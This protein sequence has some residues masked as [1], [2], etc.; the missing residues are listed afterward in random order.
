MSQNQ[1]KQGGSDRMSQQQYSIPVSDIIQTDKALREVDRESA[2]YKEMV[3]SI[4]QVGITNPISVRKM[5][6]G[7]YE[8]IDGRHR[9]NGAADAGLTEI[10]CLVFEDLSEK[11]QLDMQI[12]S[13]T[14]KQ[15]TK[16]AQ[17]ANQL[18]RLMA[19]DQMLTAG[20]IAKRIGRSIQWVTNTLRLNRLLDEAQKLVDAGDICLSNAY[21]LAQLPQDEQI[22]WI[23]RAVTSS[24]EIF[25]PECVARIK[26]L[27]DAARKGKTTGPPVFEPTARLRKAAVLKSELETGEQATQSLNPETFTEAIKWALQLDDVTVDADRAS[28]EEREAAR[29]EEKKNRAT[30]RAKAKEEKAKVAVENAEAN[31]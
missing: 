23:E 8:L 11:D 4:V 26:E 24:S 13:N 16:P 1:I 7:T 17:Y 6:D 27:K 14:H 28:W 2:A 31:A 22:N 19:I 18:R 3:A 21:H 9:L 30:A 10:P 12:V 29:E 20:D 5:E 15:D 25:V